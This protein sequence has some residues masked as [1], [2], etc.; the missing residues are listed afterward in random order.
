MTTHSSGPHDKAFAPTA[1]NAAVLQRAED[2]SVETPASVTRHPS[3]ALYD[4]VYDLAFPCVAV[5]AERKN[6]PLSAQN[7]EPVLR[8]A[9]HRLPRKKLRQALKGDY[10]GVLAAL[11]RSLDVLAT[12]QMITAFRAVQGKDVLDGVTL[13]A[14]AEALVEQSIR[15]TSTANDKELR[16]TIW[17]DLAA[18][19]AEYAK[20]MSGPQFACTKITGASPRIFVAAPAELWGKFVRT[21]TPALESPH[22]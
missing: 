22:D 7:Y 13:V 16:I 12:A 10:D 20:R 17:P 9:L 14:R 18:M 5:L 1:A 15:S 6:V 2:A 11:S 8:H 21:I 3:A 4:A 19:S